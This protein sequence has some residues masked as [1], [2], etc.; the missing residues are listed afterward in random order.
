[1]FDF[2][3]KLGHWPYR[4]VRGLD[5]LLDA[6]NEL[7]VERAAVSSLNAVHYL[8]PQDGNVELVRCIENHRNRLIPFAVIRP[9]FTGWETDLG[10]CLNQYGMKGI[11]LYPNYHEFDLADPAMDTLMSMA[12]VPVCVQ[13]GLEDPRRQFRPYKIP[14]VS[15]A[16]IGALARAYP[17]ISVIALGLKWGQPQQAGEPLPENFCFDTS[18]YETMGELEFAV[19]HFGA[20]H[21]LLGSNF[22]LFNPRA[23]AGKV[24]AAAIGESA[25]NAI[26]GGN[27]RRILGV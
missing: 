24:R 12:A 3:V 20:E 16:D 23:N 8:N 10:V 17:A 11:V 26:A 14:E 4:P 22:P 9:N 1:M 2:N 5:A 19:E 15:A 7:G 25:R 27:A 21:I 13:A 18:N 6:M